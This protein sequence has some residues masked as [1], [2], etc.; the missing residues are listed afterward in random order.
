MSKPIT[1]AEL[2]RARMVDVPAQG[3]AQMLGMDVAH[4]GEG[5]VTL[6]AVPSRAFYNL[7]GVVHGGFAATLLDSA[8][9][10][11]AVAATREPSRCLTLEIK[12][13]YHAALTEATGMVTVTGKVLKIGRRTA[14]TE[15]RLEDAAGKLYASATSTL[16]I[17][18]EA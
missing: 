8:C 14:F 5:E 11:A 3:M 2:L 13:A 18:P 16:L 12:V 9:G 15:A 10:L 1:G 17:E 6:T 7:M 4:V